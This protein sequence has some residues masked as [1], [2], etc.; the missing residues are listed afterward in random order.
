MQKAERGV[1]SGFC[2]DRTLHLMGFKGSPIETSPRLGHAIG[3]MGI[4][5]NPSSWPFSAELDLQSLEAHK[6]QSPL[7]TFCRRDTPLNFLHIIS[8]WF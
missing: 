1:P 8:N 2:V 6:M 5:I 3:F 7:S 4:C